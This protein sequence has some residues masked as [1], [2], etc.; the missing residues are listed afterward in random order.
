MKD[1][2]ALIIKL[3]FNSKV[4]HGARITI[5]LLAIDEHMGRMLRLERLPA[6][7]YD[8]TLTVYQTSGAEYAKPVKLRVQPGVETIQDFD[9]TNIP[10]EVILRPVDAKAKTVLF[11]EIRIENVDPNFR[12]VRDEKGLAFRLKPGEYQVKM[13]LPDMQVKTIP[14]KITEETY[15]Y[16]LPVDDGASTRKEARF[17]LSIPV[18][19]KTPDGYWISTNSENISSSGICLMRGQRNVQ[20]KEVHVRLFVPI[21]RV[22][23]ECSAK[24]R[25]IQDEIGL[26]PRMGLELKLSEPTRESLGRWLNQR[27]SAL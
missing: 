11:T 19:Y 3:E 14:L 6:G 27:K 24:V 18:A 13:I 15:A 21:S 20:D 16:S 22:P 8:G 25:W 12:L 2:G 7:T 26:A 17:Q 23:L 10:K 4:V 1:S 5:P 9:L